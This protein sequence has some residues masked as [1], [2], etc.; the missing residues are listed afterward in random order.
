MGTF[1]EKLAR[2]TKITKKLQNCPKGRC[3]FSTNESSSSLGSPSRFHFVENTFLPSVIGV[4]SMSS[5]S[6]CYRS[7]TS[8]NW[9]PAPPR[10]R[11]PFV[12][13]IATEEEEKKVKYNNK[14]VSRS[15]RYITNGRSS[16]S[17]VIRFEN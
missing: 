7:I 4:A 11:V 13:L 17:I 6:L 5:F 16:D 3:N 1:E 2:A 14:R 12:A 10:P 8:E 9:L 15:R